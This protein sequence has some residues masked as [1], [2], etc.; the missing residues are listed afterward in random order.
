MQQVE[1]RSEAWTKNS[2]SVYHL[3]LTH[4]PTELEAEMKNHSTWGANT[5]NQNCIKLLVTNHH[6][7]HERDEAGNNDAG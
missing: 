1:K 4:C 6:S 7:Q 2:A 3:V 5:I